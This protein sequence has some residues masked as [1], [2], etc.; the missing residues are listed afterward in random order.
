MTSTKKDP[1][2]VVLQLAGGNDALNTVVP[3]GNPKYYDN[4]TNVVVP[5]DQVLQID[6][7]IGFN[8]NMSPMKKLYDEGHM[9][10]VQGVGYPTGSRS[11][12]R[13]MDIWHTCEPAK[14]GDE[15]WLGRVV[16]DLD[17]KGENV[18][19]A[20]NFGRGL[21]RALVAPG[22]AAASVGNLET[23]G[24]LTGI[25]D[26]DQRTKALDVFSKVYSPM[27]G[28]GPV[29]DYLAHTGLDALKGAD[30]LSAAPGMYSSTVEYG[31]D[32]VSQ[33][34]R[35]I[36]QTHMAGFGT[37][38]LYTTAPFN[39]FDTHAGQMAAHTRLWT[40]TSRAVGDFYDDLK[41]HN[42]GEDVL[43]LVFTEFGRRVKDNGS[44]TDHGAGG[45]CFIIGDQVKGGLYGEYPSLDAD[46]LDDGDLQ[47][48]TD[49][50]SVYATILEDWMGLDSKPIVNGE[51]EKLAFV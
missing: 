2:L 11:H 24:V 21:P 29:M 3:Y 44:G 7:Q 39:S 30:I 25:D 9:A 50:R 49:F 48:N 6:D 37:R 40:E 41:E 16:R 19:T 13:S 35:N 31:A 22:V 27:I 28:T 33:Y 23:Y 38:V 20:V 32:T 34:M 5:E 36:A 43:L 51:F 45:H 42:A 12:F 10:I 47:F 18:L 4:R 8:P 46:K 1:V 26:D 15:G 14:V 17:P